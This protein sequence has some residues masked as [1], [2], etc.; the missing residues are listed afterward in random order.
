MAESI[1]TKYWKLCWALA[2]VVALLLAPA[3]DAAAGQPE[4]Q[5]EADAPSQP[6]VENEHDLQLELSYKKLPDGRRELTGVV[7]AAAESGRVPVEEMLVNFFVGSIGPVGG[8]GNQLT[9]KEGNAVK[10]L[11]ADADIPIDSDGKMRFIARSKHPGMPLLQDEIIIKDAAIELSTLEEEAEEAGEEGGEEAGEEDAKVV[12]KVVAHL[13]QP[14]QDDAPISMA[15]LNFE[16]VRSFGNIGFG[17]DFTFTDDDGKVAA[18]FP[19]GITRDAAG[20]VIVQARLEDH[21]EYG[22]II[23]TFEVPWGEQ[24]AVSGDGAQRTLWGSRAQTPW[25][26]LVSANALLV[27]VWGIIFY[28]IFLTYRVRK[29]S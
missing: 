3:S 15:K 23:Q 6:E 19:E 14:H 24:A 29:A 11:D 21:E 26:L 8:Y 16:V 22:T 5:P 20:K 27:G 9:D 1:P 7:T 18:E 17:G 25:W 2:A 12:R 4:A 10:V 28:V 13:Y